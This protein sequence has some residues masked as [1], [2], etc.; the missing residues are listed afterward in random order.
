[1]ER[2]LL[3][4]AQRKRQGLLERR[5]VPARGMRIRHHVDHTAIVA[6]TQCEL[7]AETLLVRKTPAC[8]VALGHARGKVDRAQRTGIAH[9]LPLC[10]QRRG[11]GIERIRSHFER[12]AHDTAHPCLTHAVT[13]VVDRQNGTRGTPVLELFKVGRGHLLKTVGKLDLT[14]HGQAV[15]L[16]KLL[17]NPRLTEK[18]NL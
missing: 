14:H 2:G 16:L 15:A 1:M 6:Q 11:N 18:G 12:T 5:Q 4:V 7:Q 3:L 9:E 8:D 17:G 13:Y 10:A